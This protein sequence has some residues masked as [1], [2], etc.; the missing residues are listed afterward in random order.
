MTNP[1]T[2]RHSSP[3]DNGCDAI[4]CENRIWD[5][6][7][8]SRCSLDNREP[9]TRETLWKVQVYLHEPGWDDPN[10]LEDLRQ[11]LIKEGKIEDSSGPLRVVV[12]CNE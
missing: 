12:E 7:G 9:I 6:D 11:V 1:L 3:W 4:E 5:E 10:K 2:C 8:Y